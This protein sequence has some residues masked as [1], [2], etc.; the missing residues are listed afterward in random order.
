[1]KT[2]V[3]LKYFVTDCRFRGIKN[4]EKLAREYLIISLLR[5]ERSALQNN[6]TNNNNNNNNN[7]DDDDGDDDTY[8]GKIRGKIRDIKIIFNRL[9][10]IATNRNRKKITKELYEIGNKQNFSDK[11]KEKIHDHLVELVNTL[12]KSEKHQYHGRDDLDYYGIND[13][14]NSFDVDV[15]DDYYKPK[16]IKSFFKNNYKYYESRG[17]K[18]KKLSVN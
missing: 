15:D 7:N 13:I 8:D 3:S 1:M 16:L 4:R 17:D 6:F 14:E 12:N 9:G 10:N 18:D 5:S 11:K 2:R